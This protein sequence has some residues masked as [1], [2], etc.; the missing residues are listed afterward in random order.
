VIKLPV[1]VGKVLAQ[2]RPEK[3]GL[4]QGF[5]VEAGFLNRHAQEAL[6]EAVLGVVSEA[7]LYVPSMPR[8]GKPLSVRM[9]NCGSLGWVTD[10]KSGYRY[11]SHHPVTGRPWPRIPDQ[12]LRIWS[13]VAE[14]PAEPEAC[15]VNF[16]SASARMGSHRDQDEADLGAPVVSVSLGDEA[17][18]HLGGLRRSD[19]KS[20]MTLRSGDV[21]V[22]G[23][24]ARVAYHGID[25][26]EPGTSD[27]VPGGGRINLTLRRVRR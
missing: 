9:T 17:V 5:R 10:Q 13:D 15:L 14:Y 16:Y 2:S 12:L 27:L 6:L 23:G 20:R 21:V 1:A 24:A 4:P 25:R 22:L 3:I 19:P 7:P 18:F 11:Q 8:S 26:I